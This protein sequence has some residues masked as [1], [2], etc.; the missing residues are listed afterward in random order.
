MD[1]WKEGQRGLE[2]EKTVNLRTEVHEHDTMKE[3][4]NISRETE[5]WKGTY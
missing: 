2:N 3:W 1:G 4:K 5:I